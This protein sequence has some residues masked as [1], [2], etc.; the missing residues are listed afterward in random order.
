[1]FALLERTKVMNKTADAKLH[2]LEDERYLN[3]R[4]AAKKF[5]F[6]HIYLGKI[7]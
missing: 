1:M 7:F 4:E 5:C 2:V 3:V 6:G